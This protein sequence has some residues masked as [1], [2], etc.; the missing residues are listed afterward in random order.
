MSAKPPQ[1]PP[2][3]K[4]ATRNEFRGKLT[5]N[6]EPPP[7]RHDFLNTRE[8]HLLTAAAETEEHAANDHLGDALARGADD[9]RDRRDGGAGNEEPSPAE[10]VGQAATNGYYDSGD[11]IP[12]SMACQFLRGGFFSFLLF[13]TFFFQVRRGKER[14]TYETVIQT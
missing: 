5:Q 3:D 12:A 13:L 8:Y 7:V 11:K 6:Q 14:G 4:L 2:P 1:P 10:D 9:G